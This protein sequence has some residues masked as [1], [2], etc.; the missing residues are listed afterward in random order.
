[1]F[2]PDGRWLAYQSSG[3]GRGEVYVRPFP[4]TA[5]K[6]SI[7]SGSAY[8]D[9]HPLWAR[10]GKKLSFA[11]GPTS[12]AEVNVSTQ[13]G[14]AFSSPMQVPRGGMIG[15]PGGPRD[16]DILPDGRFL[17]IIAAGQA[18]SG[19]SAP[20]IEVVLNWF[21]DLKQRVPVR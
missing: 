16:Y 8:G 6:Y 4:I 9:R 3:A 5:T 21:E 17:G 19:G 7:H 2:S 13:S 20:Q 15:T 18:Q 1:M 11:T 12:Q 10:D 14:F